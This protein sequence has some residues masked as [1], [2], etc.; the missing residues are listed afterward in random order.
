[1]HSCLPVNEWLDGVFGT[2][3]C[4]NCGAVYGRDSIA[5][6]GNRDQYWFVRCTCE[7]CGTQGLGVVIVK[8]VGDGPPVSAPSLDALGTA[9][10][11][12]HVD[13][14]LE[15][16]ELLR[17]YVGDVHGLFEKVSGR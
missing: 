6:V 5:V 13:D 8:R 2:V 9:E 12:I 14:V 3:R 16:H 4:A 1:M 7:T 10:A 17:D 15:A 11:R